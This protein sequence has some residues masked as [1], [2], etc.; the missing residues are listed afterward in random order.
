MPE[1]RAGPGWYPDPLDA[2]GERW[3]DGHAWDPYSRPLRPTPAA[4]RRDPVRVAVM[5]LIGLCA[6]GALLLAVSVAVF[7]LSVN[8]WA[9]NK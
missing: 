3:W 8:S 1:D 9:S 5:V 6:T 2:Q 7:M 4:G